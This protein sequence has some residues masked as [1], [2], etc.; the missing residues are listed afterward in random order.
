MKIATIAIAASLIGGAAFAG[1]PV[2]PAPEPVPAPVV[3]APVAAVSDW[4][5]F[6]AGLQYGQGSADL[7]YSDLS[8]DI[9][10]FDAFGLHAGYLRDLGQFVLGGE[11]DYNRVEPDD[12]NETGDLW[13]L[14]G[15]AGIDA[16][17]FLPY[18]T[19][20]Y[21][22]L[23]ADDLSES[24]FLYG[25]GADFKVTERFTLGLEYT[26]QE[27][28]DVLEDEIG[29]SGLDLDADLVQLRAS[30]HF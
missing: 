28:K 3:A 15:R 13:R 12:T 30:Y 10:D 21:A 14:K 24:A 26:K 16:G 25:I 29:V 7:S 11:V 22:H 19:I 20:G 4:T 2:V 6:Y 23:S 5:G 1:G 17:R 9:G 27:F 18:I 8:A